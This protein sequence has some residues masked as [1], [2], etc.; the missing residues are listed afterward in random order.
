MP[1][2]PWYLSKTVLA[3]LVVIAASGAGMD[4]DKLE[5]G[6]IASQLDAIITAVAALVA[7]Y[8]RATAKTKITATSKRNEL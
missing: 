8:G 4:I 2:K 5:A 6:D 7:I 3:A 1:S